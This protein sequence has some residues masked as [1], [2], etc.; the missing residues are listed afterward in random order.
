MSTH[1]P[2]QNR[3]TA[4]PEWVNQEILAQLRRPDR[5]QRLVDS[6]PPSLTRSVLRLWGVAHGVYTWTDEADREA[7]DQLDHWGA[8]QATQS[9]DA[10]A[11]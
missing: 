6:L 10:E 3:E 7:R 11:E 2:R 4:A 5:F 8:Q 9:A 1:N